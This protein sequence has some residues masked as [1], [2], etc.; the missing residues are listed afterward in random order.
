MSDEL[1]FEVIDA[2]VSDRTLPALS[3][4]SSGN[5]LHDRQNDVACYFVIHDSRPVL[6][7]VKL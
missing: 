5:V 7:C 4:Y 2:P 6:D 3:R 1:K